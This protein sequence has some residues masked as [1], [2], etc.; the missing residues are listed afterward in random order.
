[1]GRQSA[2][3]E[4]LSKPAVAAYASDIGACCGDLWLRLSPGHYCCNESSRFLIDEQRTLQRTLPSRPG[5]LA[6][7]YV[8]RKCR[9]IR[10]FAQPA[11]RISASQKR[12]RHVTI[13]SDHGPA[14]IDGAMASGS[15][16]L[17]DCVRRHTHPA[18]GSTTKIDSRA[19][20][21]RRCAIPSRPRSSPAG[22]P[23]RKPA[24][25]PGIVGA[26]PCHRADSAIPDAALELN[27]RAKIVHDDSALHAF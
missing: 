25:R 27:R 21:K 2:S 15:S 12:D 26:K 17:G 4:L 3:G 18:S 20:A 7:S 13:K 6:N 1:M 19:D 8:T 16:V 24:T 11:G 9:S 23:G 22:Q 10:S 14:V 5:V